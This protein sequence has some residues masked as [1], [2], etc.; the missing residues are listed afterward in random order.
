MSL[1]KG[2]GDSRT[3]AYRGQANAGEAEGELREGRE[4][5]SVSN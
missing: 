2:D 4:H 1:S 5:L 3:D